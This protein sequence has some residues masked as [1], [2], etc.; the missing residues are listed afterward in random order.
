MQFLLY[1]LFFIIFA[2]KFI[3]LRIINFMLYE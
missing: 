3:E 1:Y 2:V